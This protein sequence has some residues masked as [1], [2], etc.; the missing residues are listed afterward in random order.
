MGY[1]WIEYTK[2]RIE[3]N[4]NANYFISGETGSGK[5]WSCLRIAEELQPDFN[6]KKQVVF[7]CLEFLELLNSNIKPGSVIIWEEAGVDLYNREFATKMNRFINKVFQTFRLKNLIVLM[8]SPS[9]DFVD[10]GIRRLFHAKFVTLGIDFKN[11]LVKLKPRF[12]T[13]NEDSG[14]WYVK[15]L[16]IKKDDEY[17]PVSIWKVK[18]PSQNLIDEYEVKKKEFTKLLYEDAYRIAVDLDR[19]KKGESPKKSGRKAVCDSCNYMWYAH[20]VNQPSF[21]PKC[22]SKKTRYIVE[23]VSLPTHSEVNIAV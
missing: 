20:G 21:C 23:D 2:Q 19:I 5:S 4:K 1:S 12:H 14:K 8:N 22:R 9:W 17:L 10:V 11:E 16:I 3:N 18:K 13:F 7:G 6:V 15:R